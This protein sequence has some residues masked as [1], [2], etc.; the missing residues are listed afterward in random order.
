MRQCVI[1]DSDKKDARES[2]TF[3]CSTGIS[4]QSDWRFAFGTAAARAGLARRK[5]TPSCSERA[6]PTDTSS[7][8][9]DRN[10]PVRV[11]EKSRR[12]QG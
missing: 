5:M 7:L 11:L 2:V 9:T 3:F 8:V 12:L 1:Y 10:S 4:L 6:L